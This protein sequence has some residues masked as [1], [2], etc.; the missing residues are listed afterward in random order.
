MSTIYLSETANPILIQYLKAQG[1]QV[2]IIKK[3]DCTYDPV[4][5]HPDIYMCSL[6]PG[7][8]VFFGCPQKIGKSYPE[9]IRY[10]AACTGK[11][12]IHNLKYTDPALL[13]AAGNLQRIHVAQG[14]TRCSTAIIDETSIITSDG[15]IFNA[16]RKKLDVLL[17]R[18][19]YIR[20]QK[21]SYGF[22][23]GTS[24]RIGDTV[25]FNGNLEQHPDFQEIKSFI[26]SRSLHLKY[27]KEYSLEDIG[28]IIEAS[29][30]KS[31]LRSVKPPAAPPC[32]E[33]AEESAP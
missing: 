3:T 18:P 33:N 27:F 19:G 24:G 16:C 10:N 2:E 26:E 28:S 4:S 23:G 5:S 8:P 14:Y 22:I 15:G 25:L 9:N 21:F 12:L 11:Y 30:F 6:G 1:H 20:L 17:I 32:S 7:A 31:D 29:Q 13:N